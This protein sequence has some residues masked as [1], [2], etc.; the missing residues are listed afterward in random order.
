MTDAVYSPIE[1]LFQQMQSYIFGDGTL[2][3]IALLIALLIGLFTMKLPK[4]LIGLIFIIVSISLAWM[5]LLPMA[6]LVLAYVMIAVFWVV[7]LL[8]IYLGGI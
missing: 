4:L 3:G 7:M 8:I 5:G 2:L 1:W 6:I